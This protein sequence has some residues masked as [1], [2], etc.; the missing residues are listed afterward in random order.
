MNLHNNIARRLQAL[1]GG[2]IRGPASANRAGS[3]KD[4]STHDDLE[5]ASSRSATQRDSFGRFELTPQEVSFIWDIFVE[6]YYVGSVPQDADAGGG[7]FEH[8]LE[9]G[10]P[11]GLS[12]SPLIET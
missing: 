4:A 11:L 10:L 7:L 5:G 6:E 3:L 9:V 12:P 1:L 2:R 8:F